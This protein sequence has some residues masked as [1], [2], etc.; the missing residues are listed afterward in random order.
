MTEVLPG[1]RMQTKLPTS[2]RIEENGLDKTYYMVYEYRPDGLPEKRIA[3]T[4][5][6]TQTAVYHYY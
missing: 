6:D 2:Y 1:V 4:S 3:S 5:G